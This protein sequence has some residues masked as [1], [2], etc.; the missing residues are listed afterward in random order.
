MGF[1]TINLKKWFIFGGMGKPQLRRGE[2]QERRENREWKK[3]IVGLEKFN[4][5]G[6]KTPNKRER[7]NA[8]FT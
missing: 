4:S 6:R 3:I 8:V 1:S 5:K 7:E 2:E